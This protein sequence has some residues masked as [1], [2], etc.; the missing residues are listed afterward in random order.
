MV[1]EIGAKQDSL[2]DADKWADGIIQHIPYENLPGA[3]GT[4]EKLRKTLS[5]VRGK[6]EKEKKD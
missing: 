1:F 4:F 2:P 6:K 5:S 3:T